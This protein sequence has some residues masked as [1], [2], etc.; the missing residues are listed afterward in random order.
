MRIAYIAPYQGPELLR[1]R[2]VVTNLALAANLKIELI[3][4]LLESKHHDVEIL[5]QG[6]A[7]ERHFKLYP[8]FRELSKSEVPIHYS[9]ALP[10]RFVNGFWSTWQMLRLFRKRHRQAP[11]DLVV[12]YN[13]KEPQTLAALYAIRR[14]RLP[15]ILEY[16]DDRLVEVDGRPEEGMRSAF[17]RRLVGLVINSI[18]G[19]IGVSPHL[20]SQAPPHVPQVLLR[21]VI[22]PDILRMSDDPSI[23]R[24]KWVVFSG[25]HFRSKG[26]SQLIAGWKLAQ[27]PG[28]QLHI[29]GYGELT[30]QLQE[31]AAGDDTIVFH[32]LVDRRQNARL[33]RQSAIGINPHE[34]SHTPGNVFAFKI[35]E[36]LA[37]GTHVITTPMGG[38][39]ARARSGSD[40]HPGQ[41]S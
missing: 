9:S 19:C 33:L 29:A 21:G 8:A 3:A 11:F 31:S 32:G 20:L 5:S 10:I 30:T 24:N 18:A 35:I 41:P 13:F 6:E 4:E 17:D 16:E 2:P 23:E 39:G 12:I 37:A 26:L 14:L 27:P 1:Q 15:V 22:S 40:L 28:W 25:T 34:L 36:Y 38:T 7:G